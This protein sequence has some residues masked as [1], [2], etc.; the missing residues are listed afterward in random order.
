MWGMG[1]T[2]VP[3][4]AR[5]LLRESGLT[6]REVGMRMGFPPESAKQNVRCFLVGKNP[7][8]AMVKRFAEALGV[9]IEE[10]L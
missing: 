2:E 10:L 3:S 6:Y 1:N 4:K 8:A 7:S 9:A 5:Q